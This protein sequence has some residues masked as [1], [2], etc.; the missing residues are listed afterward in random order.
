MLVDLENVTMKQGEL[1]LEM[2]A[3]LGRPS[4]N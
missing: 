2:G 1:N 4:P 3:H